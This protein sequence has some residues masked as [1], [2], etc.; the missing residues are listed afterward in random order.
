MTVVKHPVHD[1]IRETQT[2]FILCSGSP[3]RLDILQQIGFYPTVIKSNFKEDLDK[4][5]YAS[6]PLDYIEDT[7]YFK[8]L[9]V[10]NNQIDLNNG[11]NYML[12]SADT[13]IICNKE[14]FEK[15]KTV[16]NNIKMLKTFKRLQEEGGNFQIVT[17][18][19]LLLKNSNEPV[20]IKKFNK[21]TEIKFIDG[22]NDE[23]IE[24]YCLN[25][26]GLDVAGGFKIQGFGSVLIDEIRGDY[27]NCVG[28]SASQVFQEICNIL[29]V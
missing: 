5:K 4:S 23:F 19:T 22:L 14:I 7:S 9:D 2:Q 12:L 28:L 16:E 20:K 25:D 6:N 1:K 24:N 17:F 26:E 10:Y 8:L 3:R 18:C 29:D 27:Y 21:V 11:V 15:P 13:V